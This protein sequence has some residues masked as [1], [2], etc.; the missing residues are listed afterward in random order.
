M[1]TALTTNRILFV[2]DNADVLEALTRKLKKRYEVHCVTS[3]MKGLQAIGSE[4]PFAVIVADMRMPQM[5][6]LD[7][8]KAAQKKAP[9]TI[10]IMLTG[11]LDQT[12]TVNA[13]NDG[14]IFRFLTKPCS[15]EIIGET[16]DAA[17][18]AFIARNAER[19]LLQQTVT[20]LA[21]VL[22]DLIGIMDPEISSQTRGASEILKRTA[23]ELN[24]IDSWEM[25]IAGSLACLGRLS[26]PQSIRDKLRKG[27][28]L[29]K[30]EALLV[31]GIPDVGAK[32]IAQIPRMENVA[33]IIRYQNKNFDGGGFP[34]DD[35]RGE[36][37][38]LGARLLRI[39][40][41]LF[42][43]EDKGYSKKKA[44]E[45]LESRTGIYDP[46]ALAAVRVSI[47]MHELESPKISDK[48]VKMEIDNLSVGLV[49]AA[50]IRSKNG[51]LL[52]AQKCILTEEALGRLRNYHE[53][54]QVNNPVLMYAPPP[55][56]VKKEEK[57][58]STAA[59]P[60]S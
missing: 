24:L 37:I 12:T 4:G 9:H 3:G 18:N 22:A 42:E 26:V 59:A 45:E 57:E 23:A 5:D 1:T 2:D 21:N 54:G 41:D 27:E 38:P 20:G 53:F 58:I 60:P 17:V 34:A 49:T 6:G 46:E 11:N 30:D 52:V 47:P 50:P 25:E 28:A 13:I 33:Q 51:V 31:G 44:L 40:S 8:L 7:F 15:Q 32:L 56:T 36:K 39:I 48:I 10:R 43:L 19:E 14:G 55:P 29:Q 35:I 16:I